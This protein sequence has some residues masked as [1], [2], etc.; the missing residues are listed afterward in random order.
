MDYREFLGLCSQWKIFP[1][2]L[3]KSALADIFKQANN[4]GEDSGD[5][6]GHEFTF[7]EYKVA[8]IGIAS[9]LK[10]PIMSN[11]RNLASHLTFAVKKETVFCSRILPYYTL[12]SYKQ[13]SHATN[14]TLILCNSAASEYQS[15]IAHLH[16][17][18][19]IMAL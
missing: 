2:L 11:G 5:T 6:G 7:E 8:M 9:A 17:A 12:P 19:D 4:S 14:A 18:N 3:S 16:A 13:Y 10:L 15:E 1:S